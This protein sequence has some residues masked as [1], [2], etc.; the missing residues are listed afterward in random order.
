MK[1]GLEFG[2][3]TELRFGSAQIAKSFENSKSKNVIE[4][5]RQW[6][7]GHEKRSKNCLVSNFNVL[8]LVWLLKLGIAGCL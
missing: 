7:L 2:S 3:V 8:C 5:S 1:S 4:R 6:K